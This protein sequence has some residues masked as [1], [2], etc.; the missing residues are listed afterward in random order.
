[1]L[2]RLRSEVIQPEVML[3]ITV[4][5]RLCVFITVGVAFQSFITGC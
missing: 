4:P 3:G 1:M 2:M 5:G